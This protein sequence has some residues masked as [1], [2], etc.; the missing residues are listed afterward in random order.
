[1]AESPDYRKIEAVNPSLSRHTVRY[2]KKLARTGLYGGT[3][4]T[5]A[6]ALIQDHLKLLIQQGVLEIEFSTDDRDGDDEVEK[7]EAARTP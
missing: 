1:M 4:G 3:P 2:L 7:A 6:R 5:V